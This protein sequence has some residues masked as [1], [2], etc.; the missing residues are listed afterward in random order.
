MSVFSSI[1]TD[2][3][4]IYESVS[5]SLSVFSWLTL[6]S[7]TLSHYCN[8]TDLRISYYTTGRLPPISSSWRQASWD[9]RHSNFIFQMNTYG[10][11]S[12]VIFSLT[13]GWV[14]TLQSLLVLASAVNL[15]SESSG[16]HDHILLSQTRDS[17]KLEDQVPVFIPP[18]RG[19]PGYTPRH[20]VYL[21][22]PP[23]THMVTVEVFIPASTRVN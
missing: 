5:F 15:R 3:V 8:L 7:W 10:Y 22:S 17:L 18:G 19:W 21:S 4:L 23:T 11:S 16:T 20:C 1:V 2:L 13:R 9:S 14:C 6:H 12:H